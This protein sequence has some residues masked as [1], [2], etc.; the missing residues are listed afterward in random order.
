[1]LTRWTRLVEYRAAES[2]PAIRNEVG[3][4]VLNSTF[5]HNNEWKHHH[6]FEFLLFCNC[7]H[8]I[9]TLIVSELVVVIFT[10]NCHWSYWARSHWQYT[11]TNKSEYDIGSSWRESLA[12]LVEPIDPKSWDIQLN[13]HYQEVLKRILCNYNF[14]LLLHV[15]SLARGQLAS[16]TDS[17]YGI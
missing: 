17:F 4:V 2:W 13:S 5:V 11:P 15:H 1:M 14:V 8:C 7:S 6:N 16:F 3:L 9:P 10:S 12:Q